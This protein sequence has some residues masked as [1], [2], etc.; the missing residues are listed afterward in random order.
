[1]PTATW[2]CSG[3]PA[4]SASRCRSAT[5]PTVRQGACSD[6][7]AVRRCGWRRSSSATTVRAVGSD[8]YD[9]HR[10]ERAVLILSSQLRPGDSGGALIDGNGAVV[11]VAFAIA[12]D[13]PNVA[14][15][16]DTDEVNA[17]L[18]GRPRHARR[19]RAVPAMSAAVALERRVL[20]L[21]RMRIG[22][23]LVPAV[24]AVAL[25]TTVAGGVAVGV[26]VAVITGGGAGG[27]GWWWTGVVWRSWEFRIGEDALH[28]RH[29]VLTRRISTIPYHRVQHIDTEAGPL[30][31]R[32]GLTTFVLRTASA[33]SDSTVPG[34][35]AAHAEAL[36][37]Q[38]L[39]LVGSGD[40]T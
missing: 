31:R 20:R 17:V 38:I 1:M 12:P 7:L 18:G 24:V 36:R 5:A 2:P 8:I 40:A 35:D 23:V 37:V 32:F 19:H 34:I 39:A 16:L 25:I 14:Y 33:S 21:W 28:L 13:D 29:G 15:A 4:S 6:T 11:G 26:A 22:L 10:T 3:S 27:L 30:E 9:S